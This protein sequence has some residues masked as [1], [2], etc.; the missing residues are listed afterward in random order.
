MKIPIIIGS[1]LSQTEDD[2]TS[3]LLTGPLLVLNN[4][5]KADSFKFNNMLSEWNNE[6]H[7]ETNNS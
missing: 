3:S 6:G 5:G 2:N 1:H 7:N 4:I